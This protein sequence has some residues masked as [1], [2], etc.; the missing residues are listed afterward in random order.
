[1]CT[2]SQDGFNKVTYYEVTGKWS[3]GFKSCTEIPSWENA[4][5]PCPG[6]N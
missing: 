5:G 2:K 6:M 3:P 1:M 4:D